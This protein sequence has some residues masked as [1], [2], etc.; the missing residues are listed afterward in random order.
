MARYLTVRLVQA[1][2]VIAGVVVIMFLLQNVIPGDPARV[3]APQARS[4]QVLQNIQE[5]LKLNDPLWTQF[6]SYVG[7][8][9]QGDFGDSYVQRQPVL[10]LIMERLPASS[11][12]AL[13]GVALAVALGS[14]LGTLAALRPRWTWLSVAMSI[15]FLSF[16]PFAVGLIL[17]LVFGFKLQIFP[18]TGGAGALQLVLPA[19]TLGLMGMPWYAQI[20]RD[21]L[22]GALGSV[23]V[24]TA[25][26]KGADQRTILR[27]HVLR[28]ISPVVVTMIG[29]DLGIYLSGV[30]VVEAV[31]SWPGIG[32]LA[33]ESLNSLDRPVVLGTVI[34][35]AIAIVLLNLLAD[36]IRMYLDPR[37]RR[38]ES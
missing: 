9:V 22:R 2:V 34:V 1:A 7:R 38:S 19:I 21:Q 27:K 29:L 32:D 35:S 5:Q 14:A 11:V 17:L 13:T 26:A 8:L 28:N 6:A 25:I 36:V 10:K 37:I 24:R 31:F 3:L 33:V 23:Y 12:L 18:V 20:V 15:S 30:V 4:E 16:P